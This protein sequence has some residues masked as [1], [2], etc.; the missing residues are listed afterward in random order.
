MLHFTLPGRSTAG[1]QLS[2][3]PRVEILRRVESAPGS[4]ARPV[5]AVSGANLARDTA[6]NTVTITDVFAPAV[7]DAL[8]QKTVSYRVRTAV[9]SGPWSAPSKSAALT[10][11]PPPA[12]PED[13]TAKRSGDAVVL[14]WSAAAPSR[15]P[16]P[17]SF[18][19]YRTRLLTDGSPAA[20]PEVIGVTTGFS[21]QDG[22]ATAGDMYRYAVRGVIAMAGRS[23]ESADSAPVVVHVSAP[24]SLPA[25]DG[26]VAIPVRSAQGHVEVELSW[27]I[28]SEPNLAGYNVYRAESPDVP[29]ARMN[30]RVL[31]A[32]AFR[33]TTVEPGRRYYYSVA[34]V[35]LDG[36]ESRLSV[37]VKVSTPPSAGSPR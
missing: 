37:P 19:V 17:S 25:P 12:A 32:P 27:E 18:I 16:A 21:Y 35:G 34:A 36:G 14:R 23:V 2:G 6:G 4:P 33:D 1:E 20:P 15:A 30:R 24:P 3:P 11:V 7:F 22:S 28:G 5:L 31:L 26:L 29:G 8:E 9:G 13:L 10:V